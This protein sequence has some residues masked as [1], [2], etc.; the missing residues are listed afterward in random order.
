MSRPKIR[1]WLAVA[2]HQRGGAGKHQNKAR[3][4]SAKQGLRHPKHKKNWRN[5]NDR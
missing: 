3:K 2:A 5:H 1:N 4:G